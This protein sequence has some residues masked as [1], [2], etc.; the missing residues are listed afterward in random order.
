MTPYERASVEAILADSIRVWSVRPLLVGSRM[1]GPKPVSRECVKELWEI[2]LS[3]N[4]AEK[5]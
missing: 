3:L 2:L 1:H 4:F 5:D